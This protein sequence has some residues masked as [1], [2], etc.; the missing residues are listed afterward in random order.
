MSLP[1]SYELVGDNAALERAG[2]FVAEGRLVVERLLDEPRYRIHSI[3]L[4]STAADAMRAT[5]ERRPD[6]EVIVTSRDAIEILTGFDFHRG[7]LA[8][9]Y[10]ERAEMPF[11]E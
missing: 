7:C 4:T 5:L 2:L 9:A 8:L 1:R 11:E 3:L 10:R 6:V